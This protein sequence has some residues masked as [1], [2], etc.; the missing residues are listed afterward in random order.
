MEELIAE[1]GRYLVVEKG[2]SLNTHKGYLSDLNK[3]KLFLKEQKVSS[4]DSVTKEQIKLY[5]EVL[6]EKV[7]SITVNRN[8]VSIRNFYNF[9][10]LEQRVKENP[11][12]TIVNPK[13]NKKIPTVLSLEEVLSLLEIIDEDLYG[14][15]DKAMLTLMY[16]CGLRVSELVNLKINDLFLQEALIKCKGKG[17]KERVIPINEYA[18]TILLSYIN[19][20]RKKMLV[21]KKSA[22]YLFLNKNGNQLSRVYFWKMVK[23]Y[24]VKAKIKK[25]IYPHTLRHSFATHLLENGANLRIIQTL[26]G[27]ENITTTQVYT[28]ISSASLQENYQRYHQKIHKIKK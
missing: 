4:F 26:L 28:H 11:C 3:F 25:E 5:I 27:H 21:E 14:K 9:L 13:I 17:S 1:Y 16:S 12:E 8:L 19:D 18:I 20:S 23:K 7:E 24:A 15:R 6:R 2:V 10:L 22:S